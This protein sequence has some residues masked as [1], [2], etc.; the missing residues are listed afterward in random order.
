MANSPSSCVIQTPP[1]Q[2]IITVAMRTRDI[3]T[4][5]PIRL[6]PMRKVHTDTMTLYD[7]IPLLFAT[8]SGGR[9]VARLVAQ[10]VGS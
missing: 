8:L 1:A 3:I 6:A 4:P 10:P 7:C 2:C 5:W 9:V